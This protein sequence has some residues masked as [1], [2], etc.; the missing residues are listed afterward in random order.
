LTDDTLDGGEF[1][2]L[3]LHTH[4]AGVVV[5]V[6]DSIPSRVLMLLIYEKPGECKSRNIAGTR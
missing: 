4:L 3:L 6:R 1:S 5:G 2:R